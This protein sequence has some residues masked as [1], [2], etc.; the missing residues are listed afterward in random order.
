MVHSRARH[1]LG[2]TLFISMLACHGMVIVPAAAQSGS[3]SS[4]WKVGAGWTFTWQVTVANDSFSLGSK[5]RVVISSITPV[6]AGGTLDSWVLRGNFSRLL[7]FGSANQWIDVKLDTRYAEYK[8]GTGTYQY[9]FD[10]FSDSA[11]FIPATL[12]NTY[13]LFTGAASTVLKNMTWDVEQVDPLWCK[14]TNN[15]DITHQLYYHFNSMGVLENF[16]ITRGG[17][18]FYRGELVD[19]YDPVAGFLQFL[20]IIPVLAV[21]IGIAVAVRFL[22][23][24]Y[25][26]KAEDVVKEP[27]HDD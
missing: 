12:E 25:R 26:V 1:V 8:V 10:A 15:S 18:I 23:Q 16:T 3:S 17:S 13:L 27:D 14:A 7:G 21:G 9:S 24:K 2:A 5:Y 11:L 6:A 22:L 19:T 20:G 4:P